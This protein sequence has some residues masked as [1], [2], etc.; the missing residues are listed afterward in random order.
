MISPL[1]ASSA[2]PT[3]KCEKSA[4]ACSRAARAAA[5]RASDA[6]NDALEKRDELALYLLRRLHYLGVMKRFREHAGGRVGDARNAEH[7]H[8]H[9]PGDDGL[10]RGRHADRVSPQNPKGADF[11]RGLI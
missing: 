5:I 6:A 2:A 9:V 7:L 4:T 8:L 10:R 11:G 1:P 3:L